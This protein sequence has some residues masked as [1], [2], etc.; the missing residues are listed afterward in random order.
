MPSAFDSDTDFSQMTDEEIEQAAKL[1]SE[2][3]EEVISFDKAASCGIL[4]QQMPEDWKME[5]LDTK[6]VNPNT[7][8]FIKWL[9]GRSSSVFGLS[10]VFAT[11]MPDGNSF[12][13]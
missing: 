5:I 2:T 3:Q 9:A 10:E 1:E 8:D 4:Y 6:H 11:L 12:R 13:A 7:Q